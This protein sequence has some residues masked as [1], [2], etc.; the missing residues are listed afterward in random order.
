[1]LT[2]TVVF[3][4]CVL[5]SQAMKTVPSAPVAPLWIAQASVRELRLVR[6]EL[7]RA[8]SAAKRETETLRAGV[9]SMRAA[10]AALERSVAA[11]ADVGDLEARVEAINN[12][13]SR[14]HTP[15]A[16]S[17]YDDDSDSATVPVVLSDDDVAAPPAQQPAVEPPP[18]APLPSLPPLPLFFNI[19]FGIHSLA[20]SRALSP[21]AGSDA[22]FFATRPGPV[23]TAANLR[24]RGIFVTPVARP[25]PRRSAPAAPARSR[26]RRR[27]D[28]VPRS[29]V[30]A[31]YATRD[32]GGAAD[33]AEASRA[34]KRRIVLKCCNCGGA[35]S[36][37]AWHYLGE[38][39]ANAY[40]S[41]GALAKVES[42]RANK[43]AFAC[44]AC[45]DSTVSAALGADG[46]AESATEDADL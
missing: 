18:L 7:N 21:V 42:G 11:V 5:P 23:R 33:A 24:E 1:M 12:E 25:S 17:V 46:G 3:A 9:V 4:F 20:P 8:A 38:S 39:A 43:D 41:A 37:G 29:E 45:Y 6:D 30:R 10:L 28:E 13:I 44:G 14:R 22:P 32:D 34:R 15:R 31:H 26:V 19:G 36:N 40:S 2:P 35:T 27:G 16:V